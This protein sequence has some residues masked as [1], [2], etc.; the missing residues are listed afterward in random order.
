MMPKYGRGPCSEAIGDFTC[1]GLPSLRPHPESHLFKLPASPENWTR[2]FPSRSL[3]CNRCHL[4]KWDY[5]E[6]LNMWIFYTCRETAHRSCCSTGETE[7]AKVRRQPH[8]E[9]GATFLQGWSLQISVHGDTISLLWLPTHLSKRKP[10]V[11]RFKTAPS[12]HKVDLVWT[13]SLLQSHP[14]WY[15]I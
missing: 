7:S 12:C 2:I 3:E 1:L 9:A 15:C 4:C 8:E 6:I 5:T 10:T 13:W 11:T 14:L